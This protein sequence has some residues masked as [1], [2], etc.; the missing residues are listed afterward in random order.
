MSI[1]S[2]VL[3]KH[4]SFAQTPSRAGGPD[5]D[6]AKLF[7]DLTAIALVGLL[8]QTL[9]QL[10]F[11][12]YLTAGISIATSCILCF[13]L[14]LY[15]NLAEYR[16]VVLLAICALATS[17]SIQKAIVQETSG[18]VVAWLPI[19]VAFAVILLGKAGGAYI[20]FYAVVLSVAAVLNQGFL[21]YFK[22]HISANQIILENFAAVFLGAGLAYAITMHLLVRMEISTNGLL[23]KTREMTTLYED[24]S[25]MLCS[26]IHDISTPL[27]IIL[28]SSASCE[29]VSNVQS[30][31]KLGM[32]IRQNAEKISRVVKAAREI[33]MTESG[34]T[35][36]EM[37]PTHVVSCLQ[38][39][40]NILSLAARKKSIHIIQN[41]Q[42]TNNESLILAD[43]TALTF[44]VFQNI[45][46]N[47]VKFSP[48][49]ST[50]TIDVEALEERKLTIRVSDQGI[51]IPE[52]LKS[53][54]FEPG[55][56][57]TRPG[58]DGESGTGFGLPICRAFVLRFG[59]TI[60]VRS[61]QEPT[62]GPVGTTITLVFPRIY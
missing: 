54:L 13:S 32:Q 60:C 38:E 37:R 28:G 11:G 50:V 25:T 35:I 61:N 46:S 23:D 21:G 8:T 41:I 55:S 12:S 2:W 45:I 43:S 49:D 58:T 39:A 36:Y 3:S 30:A 44:N 16:S 10:L 62:D 33:K 17:L 9:I 53:A 52:N 20:A 26:I 29:S 15:R 14:F 48:V 34:K 40:I 1:S 42:V 6:H 5:I 22:Q 24:S 31:K 57:T 51:G 18:M 19:I 59:G 4:G 56:A 47:A 7:V 27:S